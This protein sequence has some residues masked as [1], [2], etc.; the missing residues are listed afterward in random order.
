M[1]I[2]NIYDIILVIKSILAFCKKGKTMVDKLANLNTEDMIGSAMSYVTE[3]IKSLP[4]TI[5]TWVKDTVDGFAPGIVATAE[6]FYA[7]HKALCLIIGIC[8]LALIGF[9]GYKIFKSLLYVGGAAG[10]A[11]CGYAYVAPLVSKH[12]VGIVPEFIS[13]DALIAVIFGLLAIVLVRCAYG[14]AI[15]LLGSVAGYFFG[16][17]FIHGVIA[18]FFSTLEFLQG[19]TAKYIIGAVFVPIFGI[20]FLL[21]FKHAFLILSSFGGMIGA[22]YLLKMLL[23]PV[24]DETIKFAFI[25]FGF[26]LGVFTVVRQY[27]VESRS[28]EI[29]F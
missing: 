18:S 27:K 26:A 21:V 11:Y 25:L 24:A 13:V 9:E 23:V 15:M 3:G 8:L 12:L 14:L 1:Q 5:I 6:A 10:L 17:S 20:L 22:S 4:D 28:M 2:N 19:D 29:L 16:S 7:D